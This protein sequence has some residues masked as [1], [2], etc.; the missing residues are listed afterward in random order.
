MKPWVTF[1]CRRWDDYCRPL[2][3]HVTEFRLCHREEPG[4]QELADQI[5]REIDQWHDL[6]TKA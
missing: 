3:H 1:R 6:L 2:Q 5:Q 4:A